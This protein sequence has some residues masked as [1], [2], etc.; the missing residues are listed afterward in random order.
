MT[1]RIFARSLVRQT[2]V[3]VDS[4]P[5]FRILIYSRS[6][7]WVSPL[8]SHAQFLLQESSRSCLENFEIGES[9]LRPLFCLCAWSS[10]N[11]LL[12]LSFYEAIRSSRNGQTEFLS[13]AT[14]QCYNQ[15]NRHIPKIRPYFLRVLEQ[16]K[17]LPRNKN[18]RF[19]DSISKEIHAYSYS[20]RY[21]QLFSNKRLAGTRRFSRRCI[22]VQFRNVADNSTL[23]HW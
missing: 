7:Q 9:G 5:M 21:E 13:W 16:S 6:S 8:Q 14:C 17:S 23:Q 22:L 11:P 2:L 4:C 3:A 18:L 20:E 1:L 15:F 10:A 19:L 12:F